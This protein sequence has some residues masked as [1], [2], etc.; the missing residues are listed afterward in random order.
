LLVLFCIVSCQYFSFF[1]K[2]L[3]TQKLHAVCCLKLFGFARVC[4]LFCIVRYIQSLRQQ[5]GTLLT[6][7]RLSLSR[8][9]NA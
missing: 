4:M 9:T 5:F 6:L 3:L 7:L 2:G 8:N 1:C